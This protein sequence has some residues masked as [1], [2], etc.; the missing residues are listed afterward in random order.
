MSNESDKIKIYK[1]R[2]YDLGYDLE[3]KE[4]KKLFKKIKAQIERHALHFDEHEL[5]S[6]GV[7]LLEYTDKDTYMNLIKYAFAAKTKVIEDEPVF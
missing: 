4:I 1:G 5:A 2:V 7:K 3:T 6:G